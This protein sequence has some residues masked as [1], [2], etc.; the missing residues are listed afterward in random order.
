MLVH[1]VLLVAQLVERGANHT[2]IMG[3]GDTHTDRNVCL[4]FKSLWIKVSAIM[5]KCQCK[6]F[7][8][9]KII[10]WWQVLPYCSDHLAHL[11]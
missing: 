3:S 7:F 6:Y 5:N 4:Y 2:K 1:D 11:Y 10:W 9:V 8:N